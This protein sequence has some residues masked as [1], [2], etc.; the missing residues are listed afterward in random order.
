VAV[1]GLTGQDVAGDVT[2]V[3]PLHDDDDRRA[4]IVEAVRL[5]AL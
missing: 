1:V 4:L 2:L 3:E 5:L